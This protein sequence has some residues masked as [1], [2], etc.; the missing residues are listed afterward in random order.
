MGPVFDGIIC[1]RV[2]GKL[3]I[4]C[5]LAQRGKSSFEWYVCGFSREG[6]MCWPSRQG[7]VRGWTRE[8]G[9]YMGGAG[10]DVCVGRAGR[11]VCVGRQAGRCVWAEQA[12]RC[13]CEWTYPFLEEGELSVRTIPG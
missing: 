11:E 7:G 2:S 5:L 8:G 4:S 12:G 9:M 13:V 6:D 10:R 1:V 3:L